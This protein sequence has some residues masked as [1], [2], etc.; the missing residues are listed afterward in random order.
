MRSEWQQRAVFF[1]QPCLEM[2]R[3]LPDSERGVKKSMM[4]VACVG[5]VA[6]NPT[7]GELRTVV[8]AVPPAFDV[9]FAS[10]CEEWLRLPAPL[11]RVINSCVPC[12]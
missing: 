2:G 3:E 8:V 4:V 11:T 12:C 10:W 5:I 7:N 9:L 1:L 6:A